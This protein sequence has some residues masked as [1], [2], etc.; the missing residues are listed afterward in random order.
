MIKNM[1]EYIKIIL[2]RCE[3]C[4]KEF[5][6]EKKYLFTSPRNVYYLPNEYYFCHSCM[7]DYLDFISLCKKDKNWLD[8]GVI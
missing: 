4:K 5:L 8:M 6:K 7:Q 3:R 1:E 2:S